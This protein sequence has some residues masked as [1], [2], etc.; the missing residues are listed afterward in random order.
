MIGLENR[1]KNCF[2]HL[3]LDQ[4][5]CH[6]CGQKTDTHRINLHFLLHE[7]QHGIFHVDGGIVFTL[8]ELFT[9]PGHTLREYLEGKRKPHFPPVLFVL[10]M[11]SVCA[12]IHYFFNHKV[13]K[14]ENSIL[15]TN[16]S[17][18]DIAQYLDFKGF[19]A[20][21]TH[22][23]EWLGE[24]LAFTIL[25]MLPICGL[26]FFLGFRKYKY[27]YSE[28]LVILLFL[29]GQCL[30]VYVFFIFINY[31]LG[32]FNL[33]FYLICFSLITFCLIQLFNNRGKWY[34]V[35]RVFWSVFLSYFLS[36]IYI[37]FVILIIIAIGLVL[38]G[39]D[40]IIPRILNK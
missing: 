34:V 23:F 7:I 19:V 35:L 3:H 27:N 16:L 39:Y 36:V 15:E 29:S 2:Q 6:A 8:K 5:Y 31:F 21:F 32:D 9:R 25:L 22:V 10:I 18:N 4:K 1:C 13:E 12:L 40:N 11:G 38:Y 14:K 33:I 20:Y 37:V 24:H 28:W 26:A 17:K 30:T